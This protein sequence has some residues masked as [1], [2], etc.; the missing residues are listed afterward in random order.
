[1][2]CS[3]KSCYECK[4]GETFRVQ[5]KYKKN[6]KHKKKI[7]VLSITREEKTLWFRNKASYRYWRH[8]I[9]E[10]DTTRRHR[11]FE[12]RMLAQGNWEVLSGNTWK[13]ITN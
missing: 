11:A 1:M 9:F 4:Y 6:V 13:Q 5:T 10:R 2:S 8:A 3:N 12:R 7:K